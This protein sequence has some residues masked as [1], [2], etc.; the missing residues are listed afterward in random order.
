MLETETTVRSS[1]TLARKGRNSL[2]SHD[3]R[4]PPRQRPTLQL[5]NLQSKAPARLREELTEDYRRMIYGDTVATCDGLRETVDTATLSPVIERHRPC[6]IACHVT[7]T[8]NTSDAD[9][10]SSAAATSTRTSSSS[11][12]MLAATGTPP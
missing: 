7:V 3:L 6:P 4:R 12:P 9:R 1:G 2:G 10:G 8:V 11:T 5:W